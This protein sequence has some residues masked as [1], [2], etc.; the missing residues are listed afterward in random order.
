MERTPS[1]T[2][3]FLGWGE[4]QLRMLP[5]LPKNLKASPVHRGAVVV[6]R[7]YVLGRDC[8]KRRQKQAELMVIPSAF[9]GLD[10]IWPRMTQA[11]AVVQVYHLLHTTTPSFHG[12]CC[13]GNAIST[14][15]TSTAKSTPQESISIQTALHPAVPAAYQEGG[16]R[17]D[18]TTA[19]S[20]SLLQLL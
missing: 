3:N 8:R 9:P 19:L 11:V 5:P 1:H 4:N 18:Q 20:E 7:Y 10:L 12:S 14:A 13:K 15:Y 6:G 16:K 17:Q 2:Q